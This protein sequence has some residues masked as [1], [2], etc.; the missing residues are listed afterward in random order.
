MTEHF[1]PLMALVAADVEKWLSEPC[2]ERITR[3]FHP[4]PA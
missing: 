1:G 3:I 4:V 2:Q